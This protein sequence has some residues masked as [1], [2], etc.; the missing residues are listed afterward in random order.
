MSVAVGWFIGKRMNPAIG[1]WNKAIQNRVSETAA[2][3]VHAKAVKMMGLEPVITRFLN[4]LREQEISASM[5]ARKVR[6]MNIMSYPINYWFTPFIAF[7]GA[8]KLTVWKSGVWVALSFMTLIR[9][10]MWY[11]LQGWGIVGAANACIQR[12]QE[13]LLQEERVD[14]RELTD[15]SANK[16]MPL[17]DLYGQHGDIVTDK[18][19][20]TVTEKGSAS[21]V[22]DKTC[23]PCISLHNV[24]VSAK[25]TGRFVLK[26][27]NF[28]IPERKLTLIVGPVG[29]GKSV[30]TRALIGEI[31][32]TGSIYV[33]S[34]K[35]AYCDQN[36][37]L[38]DSSIQDAV[39]MHSELDKTRYDTIIEACA[40]GSDIRDLGGSHVRIG[41]NGSKL[42]GGQR[43]RVALARAVYSSCPILVVDDVLSAL[44]KRTAMHV[45]NSVFDT[46]GILKREG[47]AVVMVAHERAWISSA[48]Q[49]V[50]LSASGG[51][52]T[53]HTGKDAIDAFAETE[54]ASISTKYLAPPEDE[55]EAS[56]A[57]DRTLEYAREDEKRPAYKLDMSLYRYLY[58]SVPTTLVVVSILFV[59]I[60]GFGERC[61]ELY[62]R[63]WS[64]YAPHKTDYVW[65][66]FGLMFV[67]IGLARFN[68]SVFQL[69]VVPKISRQTHAT[70][71]SAVFG[72]VCSCPMVLCSKINKAG[73]RCHSSHR[74]AMA[75]F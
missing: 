41:S 29:A 16:E 39:T 11:L 72:Y 32:L 53:V 74:L 20:K 75:T 64:G 63:L 49:V 18:A 54:G 73:P 52:A 46:H 69:R 17:N 37:W 22:D 71:A 7:A 44:D 2:M 28:S 9:R 67:S 38:P 24:S 61:P 23:C 57:P 12:I 43:Q 42:S 34:L 4:G 59:M 51:P 27:L 6:I 45:F 50:V 21:F 66:M 31:T 5:P 8:V 30:L 35:M 26:D 13:F 70:F 68:G 1:Q 14:V 56:A 47:R 40:L 19:D 15:F 58:S 3:L 62:V 25:E 10:P 55:K 33:S 36:T 65:G 48:D 60:Y